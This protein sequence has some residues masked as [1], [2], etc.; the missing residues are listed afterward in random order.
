LNQKRSHEPVTIV[1]TKDRHAPIAPTLS[2]ASYNIHKCVGTDGAFDPGRILEVILEIDADI[3]ALQEAD[4]R[5]GD[6]RGL[7]DL[8]ELYRR[9]SY[10][11]AGHGKSGRLSHG[12]HGNVII[13]RDAVVHDVR[14]LKLPGFEP[15]GAIMVDFAYGDIPLR[16][17]AAHL[18]LLRRSRAQQVASILSVARHVDR[19]GVIVLGDMNEWRI[20]NRSA[21]TMFA[22]HLAT[23][24]NPVASFPSALP[25]LALDRVLVSHNIRVLDVRAVNSRRAQVASDHLPVKAVCQ[26][27]AARPHSDR[28][29]SSAQATP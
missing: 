25:L 6:R 21:L 15:R 10:L 24:V 8:D 26:I 14:R 4:A 1:E 7:L 27:E 22:P 12:W 11:V 17:I 18:G 19:R 28:P 20:G 13:Y 29:V 23:G 16:V 3:I 5:F 2:V 9:G